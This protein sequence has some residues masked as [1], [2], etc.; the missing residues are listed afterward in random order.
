MKSIFFAFVLAFTSLFAQAIET[1]WHTQIVR[2]YMFGDQE[3]ERNGLE[4][5]QT[6]VKIL[7]EP[8][9]KSW[10]YYAQF[11]FAFQN[12]SYGYIGP[13]WDAVNQ[14][15]WLVFAG[16]DSTNG[17]VKLINNGSNSEC[18]RSTT[19]GLQSR[20]INYYEWKAGRTY[21]LRLEKASGGVDGQRW[22]AYVMDVATDEKIHLGTFELPNN[23]ARGNNISPHNM[24]HTNEFW[25]GG[26][27]KTCADVPYYGI[28]WNGP[29]GNNL[30]RTASNSQVDYNDGD[31]ARVNG[32]T[33]VNTQNL[34]T[35]IGPFGLRQ[36]VGPGISHT[37]T[38]GSDVGNFDVKKLV[39]PID[40]VFNWVEKTFPAATIGTESIR[41]QSYLNG[42]QYV[43]DY[44]HG[45]N[46][47][48]VG[49]NVSDLSLIFDYSD[50]Q[51]TNLGNVTQYYEATNCTNPQKIVLR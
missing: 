50:G 3:H 5:L 39:D 6:D 47:F 40:C 43:R 34:L 25:Q 41:R 12:G 26:S 32:C 44:R 45:G 8:A 17:E 29:F 2:Y 4:N 13:R 33:N 42:G 49:V 14:R 21:T 15:K 22:A 23:N 28:E 19:N 51:N 9:D 37:N 27:G 48:R 1:P 7:Q 18:F 11:F 35:Q 30:S 10:G 36:E 38:H 24:A 20:C 46:G 31:G 16:W